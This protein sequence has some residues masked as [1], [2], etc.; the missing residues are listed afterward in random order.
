ME[1]ATWGYNVSG[2]FLRASV[3]QITEWSYE[4][5]RDLTLLADRLGV[6]FIL[7]PVRYIGK[8]GGGDDTSGQLD[9]LSITAALAV[10]TEHIHFISAVL[11]GFIPPA[12][13]AKIGA[14]IDVISGGRWHINLVS[15]WFQ[16]EQ[17]AFGI[18]WI[19]H[20]ERY[21]RSEEYL[22]VL[23]SL[24]QQKDVTFTGDYYS[25]KHAQMEPKP[26]QKPY[27][28]IF[29]GGNSEEARKMA[30]RLSDWYFINGAPQEELIAQVQEVS[31]IAKSYNRKVRFAVNAFVIAR[32]T[33]EEAKQELQTIVT[34]ADENVIQKFKEKVGNAKG[35]WANATEISDFVAANEG[36]RTGLIGSYE[37]V[38]KKIQQLEEIGVDLVLLTFRDPLKELPTFYEKVQSKLLQIHSL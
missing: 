38:T 6:E 29:Q 25:L 7:F 11:P 26:V 24:W 21:K 16:G 8:I 23:K 36:F 3:E 4:Y 17:E 37:Q 22:E 34:H 33:E 32:E 1:F 20:E 10:E 18:P 19:T 12:T 13:L 5:N 9:P 2:G 15:G 28:K 14:T 30:G 35:M 27:P 31:K